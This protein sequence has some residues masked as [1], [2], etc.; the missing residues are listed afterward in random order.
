[1]QICHNLHL[2]LDNKVRGIEN[3]LSTAGMTTAHG[4]AVVTQNCVTL[5]TMM[6]AATAL[7]TFY[8]FAEITPA[9]RIAVYVITNTNWLAIVACHLVATITCHDW[10]TFEAE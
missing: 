1:M 6:Y 3:T 2:D 5:N 10:I 7:N 4:N 8:S 9:C